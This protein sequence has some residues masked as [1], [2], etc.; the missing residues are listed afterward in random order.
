MRAKVVVAAVLGAVLALAA[1]CGGSGGGTE[2]ESSEG[3]TTTV[4]GQKANDHG[5]KDVGGMSSVDVEQDDFYFDP[6]VLKGRPGQ[7]LS[8]EL[9]NEGKVEHNFTIP[10][11][12]VDQDVEAGQK[13]TVMVTFPQSGTLRFYCKYHSDRGMAGGLQVG[14]SGSEGGGAGGGTTS[15][16][17]GY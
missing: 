13:A 3:G 1:G 9:E 16:S 17:S 14:G 2:A 10:S 12:H 15:T 8:I 7:K 11:Q 4:A 6:T 5:T